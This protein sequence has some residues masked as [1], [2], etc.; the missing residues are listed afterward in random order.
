MITSADEF[1]RF[2]SSTNPEEYRRAAQESA[3]ELV[4]HEIITHYPEMRR[5]VANN[6]TISISILERLSMDSDPDVRI[7]VAM[8]RKLPE[9][10]QMRFVH[11]PDR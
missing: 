1:V 3:S 5:W 10:L 11:E 2:R 9:A 6:R 7:W 4:W 8:K